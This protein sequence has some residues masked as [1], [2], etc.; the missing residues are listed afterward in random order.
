M[1]PERLRWGHVARWIVVTLL[2]IPAVVWGQQP[3]VLDKVDGAYSLN[4]HIS[5]F[6]DTQ[7]SLRI[8]QI[9]SPDGNRLFER[10]SI[11]VSDA[12][13]YS[14]VHWIKAELLNPSRESKQLVL[15]I[16]Y[17]FY[18]QVEL[19][20]VDSVGQLVTRKVSGNYPVYQR[21]LSSRHFLFQLEIPANQA[22][23]VYLRLKTKAFM[24]MPIR[25][26]EPDRLLSKLNLE[27]YIYGL[28]YGVMALLITYN[29]LVLMNSWDK[30]YLY[31]SASVGCLVAIMMSIDG[32]AFEFLWRHYPYFSY[33]S[34]PF[35]L[36]ASVV[37]SSLMCRRFLGTKR[38]TPIIDY[39][40]IA[41]IALA[42]AGASLA[43]FL[44]YA[45]MVTLGIAMVFIGA[46]VS[47]LTGAVS[48]SREVFSVQYFLLG[49]MLIV[50]G[51][52]YFIL[53]E[54]GFIPSNFY[55]EYSAYIGAS[56]GGMVISLGISDRMR[57]LEREALLA[58][59]ASETRQKMSDTFEKFVP[60]QFTSRKKNDFE[61][62]SLGNFDSGNITILF[63]DVR[64]FT[65]LSE[66][67]TPNEVFRFLN[68]YLSRMEPPIQKHGGFVDKF[69]GDAI[70]ALFERE[71]ER[72][73]AHSAILAAV[74]MQ[75]ALVLYNKHRRK[76]SYPPIQ[77]GIGIHSGEVMIGTVGSAER[78]DFTA[79]GNAVNISSRLE[80]LTKFY[81]ARIIVSR[82]TMDLLE[83]RDIFKHRILDW[84]RVKGKKEPVEI[85]EILEND[86]V[87]VQDAKVKAETYIAHGLSYRHQKDFE[88]AVKW[89]KKGALMFP[90]DEALRFHYQTCA[91]LL[92]KKVAR[93]WDGAIDMD[94]K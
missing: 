9:A 69:I 89:F 30:L 57:M 16:G 82:D 58:R 87:K 59:S 7:G 19:F 78:M 40:L 50:L 52:F 91:R 80:G 45:V 47:L 86:P 34:L 17:P 15:E 27:Q 56:F 90:K 6:K 49:W 29:F 28:F 65:E 11:Q 94:R 31:Y 3:L 23:D 25:L 81:G 88:N 84:L 83:D 76:V 54:L 93:N 75:R 64:S 4:S 55:T 39:L 62:I 92:S 20:L 70:M 74:D 53:Q 71:S 35:F 51:A 8:E 79:I 1:K 48:L 26:W 38:N 21:E 13:I 2:L 66:L 46:M 22:L 14:S 63:S 32:F 85:Y 61:E 60:K 5:V 24:P 42:M 10:S 18:D 73:S 41:V 67:M 43:L 44:P 72:Q 12:D 68:S 77:T 36:F 37:F 33:K